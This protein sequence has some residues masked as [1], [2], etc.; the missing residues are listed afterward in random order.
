MAKMFVEVLAIT[1]IALF[2]A[3][4]AEKFDL[5]NKLNRKAISIARFFRLPPP[6]AISVL[7]S[8]VS[9]TASL[10]LIS[11]FEREYGLDE[12]VVLASLVLTSPLTHLYDVI[13]FVL[14]LSISIMGLMAGLLYTLLSLLRALIR[15]AI[16]LAISRLLASRSFLIRDL[17]VVSR[18]RHMTWHDVFKV[19]NRLFLGIAWKLAIA[20]LVLAIMVYFKL[21][22]ALGELLVTYMPFLDEKTLMIVS[23]GAAYFISAMYF[24]GAFIKSGLMTPIKA[25]YALHI[26]LII[27]SPITYLRSYL[28]ER[29]A[30]FSRGIVLRWIL[31]DIS[32]SEFSLIPC[33]IILNFLM[34]Q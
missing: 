10:A 20:F 29:L 2:F 5:M 13:R 8:L 18:R 1:Y 34:S 6:L 23:A 4:L 17:P 16:H 3:G 22:D 14:P 26:A 33:F 27:A 32:S 19:T 28:P 30:F 24:A 15:L 9:P 31:I 12:R 25:V 11:K 21:F 7:F